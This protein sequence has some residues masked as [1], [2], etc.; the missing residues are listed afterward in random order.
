MRTLFSLAVRNVLRNRS[1]TALTLAAIGF[2][3]LMTV[4]L[5]GLA[6]GFANTLIDETVRGKVGAL[7]VHLKGYADA[8]DSEPLDFDF[9][10]GGALLKRIES[11]P[12]VTA[13]SPRIV[14]SGLVNNGSSSTLFLATAL[15]PKTIGRVLPELN[16]QLVGR[17]VNASAPHGAVFGRELAESLGVKPGSTLILQAARKGGQQNAMDVDVLGTIATDVP[18]ESKRFAYVPLAFAQE[19]LG[20]DGRVTEYVVAVRT[21]EEIPRVAAAVR[22]AV[23][24]Q[25]EV[26][27]WNELRPDILGRVMFLRITLSFICFVFLVIAVIGVVNTMLMSVLERTREIGTMLAV[28]VKRGQVTLMFLLEAMTLALLGAAAGAAGG[29]GIAHAITHEGGIR[30]TPP[31][32]TVLRHILPETPPGLVA[33]AVGA[34]LIGALG[35]AAYPAWRASR[36]RPVEALRAV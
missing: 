22:A 11:V 1:R 13:V 18:M 10:E 17:P 30:V 20:L 3:V 32:T 29:I 15:E 24:P 12:G 25:Y 6:Q 35:A 5:G 33:L 8:K 31:G 16:L 27:T 36:L 2:G 26:Q 9:P 28:G 19:L 34:T 14:F 23:G 21:R 4:F 7:Q